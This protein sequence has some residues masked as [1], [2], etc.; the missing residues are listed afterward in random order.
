MKLF[1]DNKEA[2]KLILKELDRISEDLDAYKKIAKIAYEDTQ[3]KEVRDYA[4]M[5]MQMISFKVNFIKYEVSR[6]LK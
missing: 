2:E 4:F 5:N 1:F 3:P 6:I